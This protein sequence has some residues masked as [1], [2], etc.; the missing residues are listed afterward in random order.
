LTL[1]ELI[2]EKAKYQ[3]RFVNKRGLCFPILLV[4]ALPPDVRKGSAF[5]ISMIDITSHRGEAQP[6]HGGKRKSCPPG[7]PEA[8]RTSGGTAARKDQMARKEKYY[9]VGICPNCEDHTRQEYVVGIHEYGQELPKQGRRYVYGD[10]HTLSF[11]RCDGCSDV[12]G[13]RTY[14]ED[15]VPINEAEKLEKTW[16]FQ[17]DDLESET[18][19]KD[20]SYV[21]YSTR[22]P[23]AERRPSNYA[24]KKIRDEYEGALRVKQHDPRSFVIRIRRA[25]EAICIQKGLPGKNLDDDL[26]KLSERGILPSLVAEIADEIKVIGNAGA[27][28]SPR[29]S[30]NV[31]QN[32]VQTI[33]DF[34]HLVVIYVYEAPSR[35]KEYQKLLR[36]K[37][38][39][40]ISEETVH[41]H[42]DIL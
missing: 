38:P 29:K 27:H 16:V 20:H 19:F 36:P 37:K 34:F 31:G 32:E 41:L 23:V 15:A 25:L 35:L 10:V 40:I 17:L 9:L 14:R 33:D 26:K 21:I 30:R 18:Y 3:G 5:P 12:V 11:F 1:I 28:V 24:P 22:Q 7:K 6:R 2:G 39:K 42:I 4:A 13:Y 8:F